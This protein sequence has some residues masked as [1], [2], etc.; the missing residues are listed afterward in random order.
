KRLFEICYIDNEK[1]DENYENQIL[2]HLDKIINDYDM[3]LVADFGHGFI[4]EKMI[5]LLENKARLMIVNVQTN[6][7]NM[8]YNMIT[9]YNKIDFA[10]IDEPEA[11]LATQDKWGDME[12]IVKRIAK[13]IKS[14]YLIVTR[15]KKGSIGVNFKEEITI[16]PALAT[17]VVDRLGAGDAF[18]SFT[19]PCFAR[20]FPEDLT[21]FIGNT[22]GA[23]AVQ[24]VGNK[25][26]VE[27]DRLYEFIYTL[28]R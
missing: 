23:L 7:A 24:I 15:G 8:G 13:Q 2:E 10:C 12:D 9:K 11:R 20:N 18:L 26:P 1:T 4:T 28:L 21:S 22:V 6:G 5:K 25:E 16:T 3:V 14:K 17:K 27:P 19:A